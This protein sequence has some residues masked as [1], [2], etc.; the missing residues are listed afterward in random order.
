MVEVVEVVV[1]VV[2]VVVG[3]ES[4]PFVGS[5]AFKPSKSFSL[6]VRRNC[7]S[8]RISSCCLA[9]SFSKSANLSFIL[10]SFCFSLLE[11]LLFSNIR[12]ATAIVRRK[13]SLASSLPRSI[14][15]LMFR[16]LGSLFLSPTKMESFPS[17]ECHVFAHFTTTFENFGLL[18]AC[19]LICLAMGLDA[20]LIT[21][22]NTF[23][24][25]STIFTQI[26]I[27]Q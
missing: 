4:E 17:D 9:I 1:A 15:A 18:A 27:F 5:V 22:L 7:L 10:S 6:C 8:V 20:D 23:I 26:K 3:G 2:V 13:P 19:N 25:G 16:G 12:R 14:E 21:K 11:L 24:I